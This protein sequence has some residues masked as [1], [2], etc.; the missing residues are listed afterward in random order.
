MVRQSSGESTSAHAFTYR[1][2]F[3]HIDNPLDDAGDF[4][5][6]F[7]T[8]PFERLLDDFVEVGRNIK[9][10]VIGNVVVQK[11]VEYLLGRQ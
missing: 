7:L 5:L 11:Q 3:L 1:L 2:L 6:R 9:D 8:E 10:G 4:S